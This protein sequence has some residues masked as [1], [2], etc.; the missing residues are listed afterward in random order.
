MTKK[1]K[2]VLLDLLLSLAFIAFMIF[3][4]LPKFQQ[5]VMSETQKMLN[6][7][8]QNYQKTIDNQ[9]KAEQTRLDEATKP[10]Y[11]DRPHQGYTIRK[12]EIC[13]CAMAQCTVVGYLPKE[14]M[15]KWI[16]VENSFVNYDS[17]YYVQ[18]SDIKQLY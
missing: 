2:K 10:V 6:T 18:F 13:T 5:T 1:L 11:I 12:A 9:K 8:T 7:N 3:Y 17:A 16:K 15:V 14:T 4:I